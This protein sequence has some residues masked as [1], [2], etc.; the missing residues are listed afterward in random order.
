MAEAHDYFKMAVANCRI[1][2]AHLEEAERS[3]RTLQEKLDDSLKLIGGISL[4]GPPIWEN[5]SL[6]ARGRRVNGVSRLPLYTS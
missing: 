4:A 3:L 6:Y 5:P 1:A 2:E